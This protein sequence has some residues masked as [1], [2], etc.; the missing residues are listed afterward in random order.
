VLRGVDPAANAV[1]T[2]DAGGAHVVAPLGLRTVDPTAVTTGLDGS[3]WIVTALPH[4]HTTDQSRVLRFDP[5]TGRVG[6]QRSYLFQQLDAIAATGLV[7]DD[8]AAPKVTVRIPRQTV[9]S[10]LARHGFIADVTTS[11]AG[12]TVMSARV[13]TSYRG[14][15]FATKIGDDGGRL[16]VLASSRRQRIRASAGHRIRLH[17]AVHDWAGN[18]KIIDRY[19]RLAH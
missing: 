12:Q 9:R 14:F 7:P 16:R 18:V 3:T 15:G 4:T 6:V 13:G 1:V 17:L 10:A 2:L 8:H 11:E 5:A 19:F